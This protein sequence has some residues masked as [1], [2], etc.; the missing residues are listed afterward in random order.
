MN[1]RNFKKALTKIRTWPF[2]PQWF[3]YRHEHQYYSHISHHI[4]GLIL[5]VGCAHQVVKTYLHLPH[6][7]VGL[8]YYDTAVHWYVA[9]PHVYADA[10][11][12]PIADN[13][14]DTVLLLDVLEHLTHPDQCLCEIARV[15]KPG[16]TVILKVPFLYPLHDE[17]LD[18]Q[19]WTCYGLRQLAHRYGFSIRQDI[20]LGRS[21]E[22]VG[23]LTNLAISKAVL[24]WMRKR[25]VLLI[26]AVI[27]PL[28]I[29]SVNLL[30]WLLTPIDSKQD[31]LCYG[32]CLIL[33]K[34]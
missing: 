29:L 5:D 13:S 34:V 31:G 21:F 4:S 18:F 23:L 19:R 24:R 27:A 9:Q 7:Y 32:Y 17:P 15:I 30:G 22:T 16:G 25:S 14:I 2:H 26:L 28:I 3:I 1:Y 8:D 11:C 20:Q 6:R 33:E 10:H 12:L